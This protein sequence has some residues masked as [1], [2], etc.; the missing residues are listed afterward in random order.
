VQLD[1]QLGL[2]QRRAGPSALTD[3][4]ITADYSLSFTV[5][6]KC[7]VSLRIIFS[8]GVDPYGTGEHVP[9]YL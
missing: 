8:R 9:Q 1:G 7:A 6:A 4:S 2:R 3:G 5:R